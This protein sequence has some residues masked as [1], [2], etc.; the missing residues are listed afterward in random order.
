MPVD[1]IDVCVIGVVQFS[2]CHLTVSWLKIKGKQNQN[3]TKERK[4]LLEQHKSSEF[5][6]SWSFNDSL[7][8]GA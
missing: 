2:L 7:S 1:V 3:Q 5:N 8:C 6:E 4:Q